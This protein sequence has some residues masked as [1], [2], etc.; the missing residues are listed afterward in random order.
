VKRARVFLIILCWGCSPEPS[1]PLEESLITAERDNDVQSQAL[2]DDS[3]ISYFEL[4]ASLP[5]LD[6][7][8]TSP[9]A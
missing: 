2:P 5:P 8:I 9:T 3:L 1:T 7:G 6:D 4:D